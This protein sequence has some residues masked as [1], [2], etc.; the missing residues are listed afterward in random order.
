MDWQDRAVLVTGA[1]GFIGSHLAEALVRAGSRVRAFCMYQS[2]GSL[3]WLDTLDP[4]VRSSLEIRQGDIRDARYVEESFQKVEVVFHLA[5]LIAIPYSY[6]APESFID[7][8]IRGTMNVLEAVKRCGVQ[9]MVHASTSE[10]Y[11]TPDIVPITEKHALKGQSPYSASKIAADKLCEA[12]A[13]SYGTPVVV[14]RPFNTYGPRQ[15]AR[16]VIPSILSQL[17]GG[18]E[19]IYVGSLWPKRDFTFVADT[20]AGFLHAGSA[21]LN[22]GEVIHLG[23]G[24]AVSIGELF[25]KA[26]KIVGVNARPL[27]QPV[28]V[29]PEQ[30]E[31]AVLQSDPSHALQ[32]LGW[33]PK[34]CLEQGL[35]ST[36]DWMRQSGAFHELERYYV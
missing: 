34:V 22:P 16:A 19:E 10:V 2:S 28:R 20:V 29:R 32:T 36:A 30:S 11:G 1:D 25:E 31:V 13:C 8:N 5:A 14:L 3:G 6:Q 23:T 9:R 35:R 33:S 26:C 17:L 4:S 7:T 18:K 12:Y 15:S 27:A 21:N 24:I